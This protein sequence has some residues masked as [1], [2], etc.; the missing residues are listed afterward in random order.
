MK[1]EQE[2]E[3]LLLVLSPGST[4]QAVDGAAAGKDQQSQ[5]QYDCQL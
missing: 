4:P 3:P 1:V 5:T 2:R